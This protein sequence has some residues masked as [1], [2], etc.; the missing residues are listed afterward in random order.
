MITEYETLV[1]IRDNAPT[2]VKE[3]LKRFIAIDLDTIN[4]S[5]K[6]FTFSN[7]LLLSHRE[8]ISAIQELSK[9]VKY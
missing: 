4:E 8:I 9:K 3:V 5:Y 7:S 2:E 6:G 1:W